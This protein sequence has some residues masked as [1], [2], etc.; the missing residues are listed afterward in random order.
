MSNNSSNIRPTLGSSIL[1]STSSSSH[2]Q[3]DD[4]RRQSSL[5][6]ATFNSTSSSGITGDDR[7]VS[8]VTTRT[9]SSSDQGYDSEKQSRQSLVSVSSMVPDEVFFEQVMPQSRRNSSPSQ[10]PRNFSLPTESAMEDNNVFFSQVRPQNRRHSSPGSKPRRF[11]PNSTASGMSS[12]RPIQSQRSHSHVRTSA[13]LP[14]VHHGFQT[15]VQP[16]GPG[17]SGCRRMSLPTNQQFCTPSV[18]GGS[19]G[20]RSSVSA[21]FQTTAECSDHVAPYMVVPLT[22]QGHNGPNRS[23]RSRTPWTPNQHLTNWLD[24]HINKYQ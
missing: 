23:G 24:E 4:S 8:S 5:T 21:R 22:T 14:G 6:T 17:R 20:R 18:C 10:R 16:C 12:H 19:H 1:Q 9:F 11:T 7:R 13:L 15:P 2:S 3:K